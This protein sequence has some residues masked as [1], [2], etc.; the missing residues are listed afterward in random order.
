MD[1]LNGGTPAVI[2]SLTGMVSA[3]AYYYLSVVEFLPFSHTSHPRV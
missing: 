3:H 1:L 2:V